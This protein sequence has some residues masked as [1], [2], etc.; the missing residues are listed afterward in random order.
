MI[1]VRVIQWGACHRWT[2]GV[3]DGDRRLSDGTVAPGNDHL[4]GRCP[5]DCHMTKALRP[6]TVGV[7]SAE[8]E[9]L[10]V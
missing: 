7:S 5:C 8:R 3:I 4:Y 9:G 6:S 1:A 2:Q 10:E